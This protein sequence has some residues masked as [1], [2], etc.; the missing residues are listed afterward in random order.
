MMVTIVKSEILRLKREESGVALMITLSVFLLLF[1]ICVGVYSIGETVRQKVELQN[2]CDSAAYSAALVQADGL[3]RM[4]MVNRAMSWTYVQLT[5]MQIDYITYRWLELVQKRF[6][7]DY[8]QCMSWNSSTHYSKGGNCPCPESDLKSSGVGWF[9]GVAGEGMN[10]VRLNNHSKPTSVDGIR[11]T[12]QKTAQIAKYGTYITQMKSQIEFFNEALRAISLKMH[13][14]MAQTVS[15]VLAANLPR[16]ENGEINKTLASDFLFYQAVPFPITENAN[17]PYDNESL[18]SETGQPV[19]LGY[20]SPLLN[21]ERDERI[22]LT[23]ADGKVFDTLLE[24]FGTSG[25][26]E[27]IAGGLDQWFIRTYPDEAFANTPYFF[28]RETPETARKTFMDFGICRAY[29]NANRVGGIQLPSYR[30]HHRSLKGDTSPSCLNT[31]ANNPEQCQAVPDSVAPYA[32]YEWDSGKY[33]YKCIHVKVGRYEVHLHTLSS[34]FLAQCS[35]HQC[36]YPGTSHP[37]NEY[38][39]CVSKKKKLKTINPVNGNELI[40][41]PPFGL[42][43]PGQGDPWWLTTRTIVQLSAVIKPNGFARIYGDDEELVRLYKDSY[44]GT[45][46]KPWVLNST[47]YGKEGATIV[48]FARKQRNPLTFLFNSITDVISSDRVNEDGIF[49]AY[50]PVD[51]GY[52][53]AFSAARAAHRFNASPAAKE[54][55]A[56]NVGHPDVPHLGVWE[57]GEYETRYDAVCDDFSGGNPNWG[58]REGRFTIVNSDALLKSWR[59]GC[60]CNDKQNGSRLARC[61]N[62]C[63]TDWD[64]TLLPLRFAWADKQES[65]DWFD[66]LGNDLE[67]SRHVGGVKWEDVGRE[68]EYGLDPLEYAAGLQ[69]NWSRLYD[70]A[71]NLA[72]VGEDGEIL[73]QFKVSKDDFMYMIAPLDCFLEDLGEQTIQVPYGSFKVNDAQKKKIADALAPKLDVPN[74][75]KIRIL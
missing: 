6:G 57:E 11:Q 40:E 18:D 23:M 16:D 12:L 36:N 5:N 59:V 43:F 46:A 55:V 9:C 2:A 38:K 30:D 69:D 14:S 42:P 72:A 64:A 15:A 13:Q 8:N 39:S 24:Y 41:Y 53:F 49:S 58:D 52:I 70:A 17:S 47:F 68:R 29:K 37:R 35:Y 73:P 25:S 26:D 10:M 45:P 62:L 27:R 63:E 1:V 56:K 75:Y 21:N 7:E 34:S 66:S 48:G 3:S 65:S 19:G 20:F 54:W 74:L 67:G 71:G 60:V 51:N 22:F 61:W 33:K 44:A 50:N 4:A 31:H 28:P 32:D